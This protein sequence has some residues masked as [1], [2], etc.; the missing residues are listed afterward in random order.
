MAPNTV[1]TTTTVTA[2]DDENE[3]KVKKVGIESLDGKRTE[4]S[5]SSS[6]KNNNYFETNLIWSNIIAITL[7]HGI[8]LY[9][10]IMFPYSQKIKLFFFGKFIISLLLLKSNRQLRNVNDD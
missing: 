10:L 9:G 6:N 3:E 4:N 8:A 5:I 7:F 2:Y 1:T